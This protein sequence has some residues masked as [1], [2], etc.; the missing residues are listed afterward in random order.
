MLRSFTETRCLSILVQLLRGCLQSENLSSFCMKRLIG[1]SFL[2][3]SSLFA[4]DE[5]SKSYWDFHPL[6][7]GG[8]YIGI[9]H[10]DVDPKHNLT[11]LENGHLRY[12]KANAFITMLL[13]ISRYSY[14]FPRVEWNTFTMDWNKNPKFHETQFSFLQFALTFYSI[15][16][17][18]WRWIARLDY[19][20]DTKHLSKPGLYGLYSALLWGAYQPHRK[21]HY[22][23]GVLGYTG[24]EGDEVFPIIGFDYAPN[25]TWLF[26]AIFPIDYSIQYNF[27][28]YFR[29]S[30]KIRPLKERFRVGKHEPQPRSVFNYSSVG[31]EINLHFEIERRLEFEIYGGYNFGGDFYIKDRNGNNPLYT[32]VKGAPYAGA[33]LDFGF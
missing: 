6:H 27:W 28:E 29:L 5:A 31:G 17:E 19:N 21:W 1:L 24:L 12:Q 33:N 25:K 10:A 8:N 18:N 4:E 9:F 11:S 32:N 15:G 23:I 14:F 26:Q 3:V 7:A 22:H 2:F 30:A 13:P 16:L 20:I